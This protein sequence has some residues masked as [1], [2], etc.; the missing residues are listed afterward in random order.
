MMSEFSPLD[1]LM[2]F[3]SKADN[4]LNLRDRFM[5]LKEKQSFFKEHF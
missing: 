2:S 1:Y 3:K 5:T 4:Q